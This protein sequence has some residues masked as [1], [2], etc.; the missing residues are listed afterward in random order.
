MAKSTCVKCGS[1]RFEIRE[2]LFAKQKI[3][4]QF[5][6]CAQCGTPIGVLDHDVSSTTL[7]A[8]AGLLEELDDYFKQ[9]DQ[10]VASI[11]RISIR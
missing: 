10:L 3:K 4:V 5:V 7:I 9:S 6:Q 8:C 11:R 1:T 2:N